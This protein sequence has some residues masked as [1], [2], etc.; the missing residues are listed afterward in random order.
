MAMLV[1]LVL[2]G[3]YLFVGQLSGTQMRLANEQRA[4]A[5][6]DVRDA[7]VGRAASDGNRP[8]SLPCPALDEDGV[9][10]L[11]VGNNCPTYIGRLPWSTLKVGDLRDSAGALLWYALAPALRDD[12]SAEPINAETAVELTLNGTPDVAAIIFSPGEPL[13]TQTGRPGNAVSDFLDGSNNDGDNAYVSGPPTLIF[14]D[15]ALAV[16]RGDVFR[17]VNQRVLSEISGPEATPPTWG[18][19]KYFA[20]NGTF[21]WAD[22]DGDGHADINQAT[23]GLPY[24]DLLL[25]DPSQSG[26]TPPPLGWLNANGWL[27]L[28]VY[29]RLS[30]SS[31]RITIGNS[32]RDIVLP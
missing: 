14:N 24:N 11:L 12:N 26:P 7:L 29:R 23:G 4:A 13:P 19:R 6:A 18:L 22:T 16:T 21:P 8:G 30:A 20:D 1:L 15:R 10:P 5:L 32:T 25:V 17:T 3:L 9:S 2:W 31:A 27:P 28:V